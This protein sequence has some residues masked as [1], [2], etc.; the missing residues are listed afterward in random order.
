MYVKLPK[1]MRGLGDSAQKVGEASG[2]WMRTA[3]TAVP[4]PPEGPA[5][6]QWEFSVG[7]L[8]SSLPK[9]PP[10]A[11]KA[12][13][14]LDRLGSVRFG[15]ESVGFDGEEIAWKDVLRIQQHN[16]AD[17]LAGNSIEAEFER[18]RGLLPP[19][20][21]RKWAVGKAAGGLTTVVGE[22]RDR[23]LSDP[24]GAYDI[25]CEIVHRG[26]FGREKS[27]HACMYSTAV[28]TL[29]PDFSAGLIATARAHGVQVLPAETRADDAARAES[30]KSLWKRTRDASPQGDP[31]DG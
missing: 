9:V 13:G 1:Q 17:V 2:E 27:L 4:G 16:G 22:L 11:A 26:R 30:M 15:P 28:L 31:Q 25:A 3:V 18:L 20:P 23:V 24:G 5:T 19:V 21:G 12:L 8:I 7:S 14:V 6:E 29:R 10:G